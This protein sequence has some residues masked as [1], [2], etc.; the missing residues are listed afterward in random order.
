MGKKKEQV[1]PFEGDF[2]E[3]SS[4]DQALVRK[5]KKNKKKK[6]KKSKKSKKSNESEK[7]KR[8][9]KKQKDLESGEF[10]SDLSDSED[11]SS[12]SRSEGKG[13]GQP[14]K[15]RFVE[16][17][18][19]LKKD[20]RR[21]RDESEGFKLCCA[22]FLSCIGIFVGF[23]LF[24]ANIA[25]YVEKQDL[26]DSFENGMQETQCRLE[27]APSP[28]SPLFWR[29]GLNLE[30]ERSHDALAGYIGICLCSF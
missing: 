21:T 8:T 30:C 23:I 17:A 20:S 25:I 1:E 22:Y 7:S 13:I 15:V 4:S 14:A 3:D 10:L 24:V 28:Y 11:G 5:K 27:T 18:S 19:R 2:S 12:A 9:K 16:K 6:G 29:P 26:W